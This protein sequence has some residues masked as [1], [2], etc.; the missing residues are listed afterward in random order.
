M[1]KNVSPKFTICFMDLASYLKI[2]LKPILTSNLDSIIQSGAN[3]ISSGENMESHL[4]Q[5]NLASLDRQQTS[6]IKEEDE[7]E[8][9]EDTGTPIKNN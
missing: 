2:S 5:L 9:D 3:N 8:V 1:H 7:H 4:Q 6:V